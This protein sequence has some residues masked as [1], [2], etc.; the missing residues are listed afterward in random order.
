M[1]NCVATAACLASKSLI[2]GLV[3]LPVSS[4]HPMARVVNRHS[5][6]ADA[7][8]ELQT[9][10][11]NWLVAETAEP[12]SELSHFGFSD[13]PLTEWR[14][15]VRIEEPDHKGK[16]VAVET[17][18]FTL[19]LPVWR[20]AATPLIKWQLR[21]PDRT[22]A[23]FWAPPERFDTAGTQTFAWLIFAALGAA[24]LGTL[25]SQTLTFVAEEF[26]KGTSTQ[27][28]VTSM[29]RGGALLAL[30]VVR[31][32]DRVGRR[33][34]LLIAG[35]ASTLFAVITA[36]SPNIWFFGATQTLSR[37]FATGFGIMIGILAAEEAPA[38]SRAWT[39]SVLTLFAGLGSGMVLWLLPVAGLGP[40]AWR[41]IFVVAAVFA[42]VLLM[43]ARRLKESRRFVAL[44]K[45]N[46]APAPITPIMRRRFLMLASVGIAL[47][48][49]SAPAS[50]FQNEYLRED[51]G[52]SPTR[53]SLF[54]AVV[55]TP[56]GVGVAIAGPQADRRGRRLVAII[57]IL[58]GVA[59]A[60][61]RYGVEGPLM[62]LAGGMG[63]II[64]AAIIPALGVY[65]PE[66]F[67]TSRRGMANGL[68]TCV[69]VVGAVVGLTFVGLA[70]EK[71]EWSFGQSFA[72]LAIVP[73]LAILVVARYP[74]TAQ[75]AL[76]ELNP[77]D[78][79]PTAEDGPQPQR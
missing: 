1:V 8:A 46:V 64:G 56:V 17:I 58:G 33:R 77:E 45:R 57:G 28:F 2:L 54:S 35:A 48:M 36:V 30:L 75:R 6:D 26:D 7:L 44:A 51:R 29:T 16:T 37:G 74:E 60:V 27:G 10:R 55:N 50:N 3:A 49:F 53:I 40:R 4:L 19:A 79:P 78:V 52:F 65:G 18:D 70:T 66:L 67:P 5:V 69:S 63:T 39:A 23:P 59:F 72:L 62:W 24:Y 25:L 14:R 15:E 41:L 32:A 12:S 47:S 34:M 42:P 31:Q 38:G 13:G 71:L 20:V 61:V 68:L 73:L 76:E 11:N 22:D 9:P 43:L 21:R